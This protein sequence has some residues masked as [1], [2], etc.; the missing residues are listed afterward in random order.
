MTLIPMCWEN[1][2]LEKEIE[3]SSVRTDQ[4]SIVL[5]QSLRRDNSRP[6][7]TRFR[8][9]SGTQFTV[10]TRLLS[11]S[12]RFCGTSSPIQLSA[13][14]R[15]ITTEYSH[16]RHSPVRR[17]PGSRRES[18]LGSAMNPPPPADFGLFRRRPSVVPGTS[19]HYAR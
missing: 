15:R 17:Y 12:C 7:I 9:G 19:C 14:V 5:M 18:L 10:E 2:A 16:F 11:P 3:S 1:F 4:A 13:D 6:S 8:K